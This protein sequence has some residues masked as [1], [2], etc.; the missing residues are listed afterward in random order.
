MPFEQAARNGEKLPQYELLAS[1][2]AIVT[3]LFAPPERLK[4]QHVAL[5]G[6]PSVANRRTHV[7]KMATYFATAINLILGFGSGSKSGK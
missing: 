6:R 1:T 2:G 5:M 4:R 7:E 3:R